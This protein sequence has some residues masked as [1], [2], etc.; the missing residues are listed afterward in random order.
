M[1]ELKNPI[2]TI[3][4]PAG[5]GKSTVS[6]LLAVRLGFFYLDTG[7]MYRAVAWQAMKTG[8]A[9]EDEDGLGRLCRRLDLHFETEEGGSRLLIGGEDITLAIR[10]PEM[11][12]LS[13][14]ISAVATVREAMTGLQRKIGRDGGLVAEGRDMGTVV[15][16]EARYKFFVSAAPQIRAER[17][18]LERLGRGE[19]VRRDEVE[20]E[21]RKRDEQD[22]RRAIAPLVAAKDAVII[23]TTSLTPDEVVDLIVGC[24]EGGDGSKET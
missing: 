2:V 11:D 16:P 1:E 15:F 22:S 21:L 5:S 8:T 20:T 23:D 6:K 24:M 12:L 19:T 7:A 14:R 17:R 13:S 9:P 4:G 10:S 18:Y 3:D